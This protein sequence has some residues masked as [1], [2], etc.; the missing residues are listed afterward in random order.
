MW[1][2]TA[3]EIF[4]RMVLTVSRKWKSPKMAVFAQFWAILIKSQSF[5]LDELTHIGP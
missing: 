2:R 1:R 4:V 3:V 5:D